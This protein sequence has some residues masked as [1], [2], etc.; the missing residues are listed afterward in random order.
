M[1]KQSTL[2]NK[3]FSHR[4]VFCGAFFQVAGAL[5]RGVGGAAARG[6]AF[7]KKSSAKN[8]SMEKFLWVD[9]DGANMEAFIHGGRAQYLPL[10]KTVL[11]GAVP[12][13][14]HFY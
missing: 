12:Y 8:F 4:K 11:R 5:R 14:A 13:A 6:V 10:A 3:N 2:A 9:L 1:F 7:L